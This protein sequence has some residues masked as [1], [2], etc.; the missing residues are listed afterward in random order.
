MDS[1]GYINTNAERID[2]AVARS[3]LIYQAIISELEKENEKLRGQ[4]TAQASQITRLLNHVHG[5]PGAA[6]IKNSTKLP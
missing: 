3:L 2:E 4:L 1:S 6:G 5:I